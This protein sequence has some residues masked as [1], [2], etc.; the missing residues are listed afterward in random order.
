MAQ[1]VMAVLLQ[2]PND[3]RARPS[4]LI[5]EDSIYNQIFSDAFPIE[6]YVISGEMKKAVDLYLR[7][8]TDLNSADKNNIHYHVLTRLAVRL[9]GKGKPAVADVARIDKASIG[10]DEIAR[11][12]AD[13]HPIYV[14]LGADGRVAK[15]PDFAT[16]VKELALPE[17][18]AELSPIAVKTA[19]APVASHSSS[20]DGC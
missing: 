12:F 11:A 16:R 14:G 7:D 13:V 18:S 6:L 5:K 10:N 17:A 20:G 2:R 15:G 19:A 8:E 1:T 3:A 4:S 9:T